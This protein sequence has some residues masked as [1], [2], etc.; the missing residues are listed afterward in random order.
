MKMIKPNKLKNILYVLP[1]VA[2]S[3]NALT[4]LKFDFD[5]EFIMYDPT[6][7]RIQT[8][9]GVTGNMEME[10]PLLAPNGPYPGSASMQGDEPFFGSSWTA[11]GGITGYQNI[12]MGGAPAYCGAHLMCADAMMDFFWSGNVIPVDASF[13]LDPSLSLDFSNPVNSIL[14][15]WANNQ[16]A[17]FDVESL[18]ADYD[19]ILGTAMTQGPFIGF[20]PYFAGIATVVE[21]CVDEGG[22]LGSL[23]CTSIPPHLEIPKHPPSA[24]PVPA[25]V[26]LFGSGLL[27]LVGVARRRKAAA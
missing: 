21:V 1:F 20:T 26:W 7:T 2:C 19:G 22:L 8:P 3:A 23:L 14:D 5:G 18:D 9:A 15:G 11:D 17:Y 12:L 13:A 10:I 25:A 4:V 16:L 6:G 24:V 27:G